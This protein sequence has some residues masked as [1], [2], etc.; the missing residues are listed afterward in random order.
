MG[1]TK[2]NLHHLNLSESCIGTYAFNSKKGKSAIDHMLVN[3]RM[4]EEFRGMHIDEEKEFL[5]ISDHCLVRAWFKM[6]PKLRTN[7]KKTKIKEIQ[8][9]K[10]DEESLKRFESALLP[11]IGKNTSF[12]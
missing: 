3:D 5:N 10:K 4:Y 1:T 6:S 7:W 8:W 2:Y 12:E 11:K 9:I